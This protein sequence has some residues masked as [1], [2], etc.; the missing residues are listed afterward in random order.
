VSDE[1]SHHGRT[2][3]DPFDVDGGADD[4]DPDRTEFAYQRWQIVHD[5]TG[6]LWH[7]TSRWRDEDTGQR[8][9]FLEDMTWTDGERRDAQWL[10]E[11]GAATGHRI[12]GTK[13]AVEL[14]YRVNGRLCGPEEAATKLQRDRSNDR[15][16]IHD[17]VPCSNCEKGDSELIDHVATLR[18]GVERVTT[19]CRLCGHMEVFEDVD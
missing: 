6:Q 5:G 17:R 8:W 16:C 1:V 9:Y 19:W 2:F 18:G 14:G 12:E 7:I 13:P 4:P 15:G 3:V 10:D 11:T